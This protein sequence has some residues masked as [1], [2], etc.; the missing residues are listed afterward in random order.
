MTTETTVYRGIVTFGPY[1]SVPSGRYH[2]NIQY[3]SPSASAEAIGSCDV[4]VASSG[5]SEQIQ[6]GTLNG[7]KGEASKVSGS[8]NVSEEYNNGKVE[9][10]TANNGFSELTIFNLTI[11]KVD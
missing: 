5:K 10:R 1:V 3:S 11:T 6:Q 4:V 2:F 9:V 7:S 8:F